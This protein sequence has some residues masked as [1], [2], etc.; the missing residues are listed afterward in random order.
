M[1]LRP[2]GYEGKSAPNLQHQPT[3]PNKSRNIA[4]ATLS[5]FGPF[6]TQFT[7]SKRTASG[8]SLGHRRRKTPRR[9]RSSAGVY[10]CRLAV[11]IWRSSG[12]VAVQCQRKK[13]DG[14]QCRARALTGKEYCALHAEPGKAAELVSAL[15]RRERSRRLHED[16]IGR[17]CICSHGRGRR[18]H[19]GRLIGIKGDPVYCDL[20]HRHSSAGCSTATAQQRYVLISEQLTWLSS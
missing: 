20:C 4:M 19:R 13:R 7:D 3:K 1:N 14:S 15:L 16:V 2:L 17:G 11:T 18:C 6:L 8:H 5:E 10:S 12:G 9:R